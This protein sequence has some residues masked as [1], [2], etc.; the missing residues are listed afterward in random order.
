MVK[1]SWWEQFIVQAAVSFLSVLQSQI[2]NTAELAA[3]QATLVFLHKLLGEG[4]SKE[5]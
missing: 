2:K 5:A 1:L 4:V 3:L